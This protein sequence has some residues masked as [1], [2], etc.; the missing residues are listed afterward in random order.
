[1][2]LP[3]NIGLTDRAIRIAAGVMAIA[4]ASA[5]DGLGAVI[6]MAIGLDAT[7]TGALGSS[8]LYDAFD[9]DTRPAPAR[10]A[11]IRFAS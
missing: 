4:L 11:R 6:A 2:S 9:L 1:M 3:R 7:V 8:P 5:L 10:S